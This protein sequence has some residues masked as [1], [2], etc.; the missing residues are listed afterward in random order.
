MLFYACIGYDVENLARDQETAMESI[1]KCYSDT[2]QELF[3]NKGINQTNDQHHT[4]AY[5]NK[6]GGIIY[7]LQI[8]FGGWL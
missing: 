6:E 4:N 1:K 5:N 3:L 8:P 7:T 2:V